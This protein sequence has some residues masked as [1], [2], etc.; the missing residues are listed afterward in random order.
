[1]NACSCLVL[2]EELGDF[3]MY[4]YYSRNLTIRAE[5]L[6]QPFV[7][8]VAAIWPP[9]WLFVVNEEVQAPLAQQ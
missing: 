4:P 1:M 6:L 3:P 7:T 5:H 2:G 9:R 8:A